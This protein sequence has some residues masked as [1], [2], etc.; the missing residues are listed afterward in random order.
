MYVTRIKLPML[1][2]CFGNRRGREQDSSTHFSCRGVMN[3]CLSAL[4]FFFF[5]V[6]DLFLFFLLPNKKEN[7]LGRMLHKDQMFDMLSFQ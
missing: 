6:V 7:L 2:A 1:A 5:P 3:H 4:F